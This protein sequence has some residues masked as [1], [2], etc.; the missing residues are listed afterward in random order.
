MIVLILILISKKQSINFKISKFITATNGK[1]LCKV[2]SIKETSEE[3]KRNS[4]TKII[5]TTN[6]IKLSNSS[7]KINYRNT[8]RYV[9]INYIF[10]SFLYYIFNFYF[11]NYLKYHIIF[12][13]I[14]IYKY[15]LNLLNF[16]YYIIT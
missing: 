11:I 10:L 5:N 7:Q 15:I 1:K 3:Y 13:I 12:Y 14:K 2:R 9:I 16:Y 8:I 6:G 4:S